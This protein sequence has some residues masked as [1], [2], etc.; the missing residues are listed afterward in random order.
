MTCRRLGW[1]VVA[2]A[3]VAPAVPAAAEEGG[4]VGW[5][6]STRGA[7]I[8]GA[9]ISLFGKGIRGGNLVTLA[10]S[11][12]QF[13]LPALAPGSYT[14]RA[15]G[16]GH[17][18]SAARQVTVLPNRDSLFTVS[19]TPVGEKAT[20]ASATP[21]A[22]AEAE[23]RRE[24][25]WLMR[26]KRRSV[27]ETAE[28]TADRADPSSTR[29]AR[30]RP[31]PAGLDS[32]G[33]VEGSVEF[34]A[35]STAGTLAD[36]G[37]GLPG[38]LGALHLSGRLADGVQWSLG[39][40]VAEHEGRAWRTSA[41]FVLD[42][43]G[44]HEIQAGAGYGVGDTRAPL[45]GGLAP[46]ERT[47]GAVFARDRWRLSDRVTASAGA[48]YTYLGFLPDSNH[49][50]AVVQIEL[51]GTSGTVL[52]GSIST[53]SLAPGGDLLTLS[54]VA[55]SPA[56]T[57]ARLD[58]NLRPSRTGRV[59]LGVDRHFAGGRLGAHVFDE[60]T[61][62]ALLTVFDGATPVVRNAGSSD[63]R[64]FGLS[65]G[66][67]FGRVVDG[68]LTYTYGRAERRPGFAA[69]AALVGQADF[70]DLVARLETVI[71]WS[72]TRLAAFCRLNSLAERRPS[73]PGQPRLGGTTTRFDFQV[74]Q[75][76]PF[77][78][79]LTRADWEVLVAVRNMFYEASEGGFLDELAVQDPPTRVVGGISVRF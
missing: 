3:L 23:A 65:V 25:Q 24:W 54:T 42:P 1:A 61:R 76:L 7:P 51:Q 13:V 18:P 75:G 34:V 27:L 4:V 21:S 62:D 28:H 32:L 11:Q 63:A 12:G 73:L 46:P 36:S 59:E 50:D 14:L 79:P 5:V 69:P 49:A 29:L 44:G 6:E 15:I 71:D 45:P 31:T 17:Q 52:R 16:T 48:R 72:D 67:R 2:S 41:E 74:T 77:L 55:A 56:I 39:G 53:R 8:A 40:L 19:L 30:E 68:S 10:D 20:N 26:H 70:H 78:A 64:G 66:R 33:A 57:W 22:D 43:G 47:T 9:V 38:G 60:S 37:F 35:A 58:D